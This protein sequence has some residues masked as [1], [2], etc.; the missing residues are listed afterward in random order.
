MNKIHAFSAFATLSFVATVYLLSSGGTGF[1]PPGDRRPLIVKWVLTDPD[2]S[3]RS[4]LAGVDKFGLPPTYDSSVECFD[5]VDAEHPWACL[6]PLNTSKACCRVD[7]IYYIGGAEDDFVGV[8]D[9]E[10]GVKGVSPAYLY[11]QSVRLPYRK[12]YRGNFRA[13]S[14]PLFVIGL[15][16]PETILG[17]LHQG[18]L[19]PSNVDIGG[20]SA[21][22]ENGPLDGLDV[23]YSVIELDRAQVANLSIVYAMR[24]F[25]GAFSPM[26]IVVGGHSDGGDNAIRLIIGSLILGFQAF[27]HYFV[28]AAITLYL[29]FD[30]SIWSMAGQTGVDGAPLGGY[31]RLNTPGIAFASS[32]IIG[33]Q[34]ST[35]LWANNLDYEKNK[36]IM[37]T[38]ST[39]AHY[40]PGQVTVYDITQNLNATWQNITYASGY[41]VDDM[42]AENAT[43]VFGQSMLR[44]F[45]YSEAAAGGWVMG[46]QSYA[47]QLTHFAMCRAQGYSADYCNK[48]E[49][50]DNNDHADEHDEQGNSND[51][52]QTWATL[53]TQFW[54][55]P[56]GCA[57]MT[58]ETE[59]DADSA[60]D[61]YYGYSSY[62]PSVVARSARS[63]SLSSGYYIGA[64]GALGCFNGLNTTGVLGCTPKQWRQMS[65][66]RPKFVGPCNP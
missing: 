8:P 18:Q 28:D 10:E 42:L 17:N 23:P 2:P 7:K 64:P 32:S 56:G 66:T 22:A 29:S 36:W 24:H 47:D 53:H 31:E 21:T 59:A 48:F 60:E 19:F 16:K 40:A 26:R 1:W 12:M 62:P 9:L 5:R 33:N 58:R 38:N 34:G 61:H 14:G 57:H 54:D 27:A 6:P 41:P 46:I 52:A 39:H 30:G 11:N 37:P 25:P 43:E 20:L 44:Y 13:S 63:N 35:V 4:V 55:K 3:R 65:W 49:K 45:T 50:N 15:G 51:R